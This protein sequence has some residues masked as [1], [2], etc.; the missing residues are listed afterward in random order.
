MLKKVIKC[1]YSVQVGRSIQFL[2]CQSM[3]FAKT[4]KKEKNVLITYIWLLLNSLDS[5]R[6]S[7]CMCS[8][9][10][11]VLLAGARDSAWNTFDSPLSF[12][13]LSARPGSSLTVNQRVSYHNKLRGYPE[14]EIGMTSRS[15][16]KKYNRAEL[17]KYTRKLS[18]IVWLTITYSV[19]ESPQVEFKICFLYHLHS[20]N[21]IYTMR[22]Y[23][24]SCKHYNTSSVSFSLRN[25]FYFD[26][27]S[28][29]LGQFILIFTI[30]FMTNVG[31]AI[32]S[33]TLGFS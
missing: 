4:K 18:M 29:H 20:K 25:L 14:F 1:I 27:L 16:L 23:T 24:D 3:Y 11:S 12:L 30:H 2:L 13:S 21:E 17:K 32:K 9:S 19:C 28:W 5:I 8:A 6:V 15:F 10:G 31:N 7:C 26:F 33:W 22:G